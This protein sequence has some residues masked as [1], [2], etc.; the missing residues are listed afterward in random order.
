MKAYDYVGTDLHRLIA[1]TRDPWWYV[2]IGS[3]ASHV[4]DEVG[5]FFTGPGYPRSSARNSASQSRRI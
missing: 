3:T 1:S 4:K 5:R 2:S